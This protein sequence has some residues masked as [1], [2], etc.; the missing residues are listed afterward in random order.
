MPQKFE[1]ALFIVAA[2]R[3]GGLYG[4]RLY[5][6]H[7]GAHDLRFFFFNIYIL[8]FFYLLFLNNK[9]NDNKVE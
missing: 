2:L 7:G 9:H 4:M 1:I 3:C 5:L 6:V 8:F